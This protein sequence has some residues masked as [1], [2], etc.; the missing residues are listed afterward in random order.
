MK[1]RIIGAWIC[2]LVS[3]FYLL[4]TAQLIL[5]YGLIVLDAVFMILAGLGGALGFSTWGRT[6]KSKVGLIAGIL[7]WV[8]MATFVILT[9]IS[10]TRLSL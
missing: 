8:V 7:G 6:Q 5:Q 3:L 10:L 1:A 2:S 9:A 4:I